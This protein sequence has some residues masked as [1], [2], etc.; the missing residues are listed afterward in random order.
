LKDE[1]N[2][3]RDKEGDQKLKGFDL[4]SMTKDDKA[5]IGK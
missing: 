1:V 5:F 4:V 3:L 2:N